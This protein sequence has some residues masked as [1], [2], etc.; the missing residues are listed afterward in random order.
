MRVMKTIVVEW[1][2]PQSK[3]EKAC[4]GVTNDHGDVSHVF[5]RESAV[6][7]G[8]GIDTFFHELTHVFFNFHKNNKLTRQEEE[9]VARSVGRAARGLINGQ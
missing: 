9:Q 4:W 1:R 7:K 3:M 8:I 2:K 6:D 5:I